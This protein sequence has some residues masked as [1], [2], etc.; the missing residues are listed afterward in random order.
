MPHHWLLIVYLVTTD[1]AD[2][3]VLEMPS[4]EK[5][6]AAINREAVDR[7]GGRLTIYCLDGKELYK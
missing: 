3:T 1:I 6:E 7:S 2:L 5:C 4:L